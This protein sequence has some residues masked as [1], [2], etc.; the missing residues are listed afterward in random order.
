MFREKRC[1]YVAEFHG[2]QF[3]SEHDRLAGSVSFLAVS[4]RL[5]ILGS[6]A[7]Y[8]L[9]CVEFD[10]KAA[11]HGQEPNGSRQPSSCSIAYRQLHSA[12]YLPLA[13]TGVETTPRSSSSSQREYRPMT[14]VAIGK[15]RDPDLADTKVKKALNQSQ[16]IRR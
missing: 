9:G 7:S 16:E 5:P 8:V 15:P 11:R 4:I 2:D 14:V 12:R 10:L 1:L 6:I 13:A 3:E